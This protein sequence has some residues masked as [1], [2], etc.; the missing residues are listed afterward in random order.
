MS[1][2]NTSN[3]IEAGLI[4]VIM[5][6]YN[7][8]I[9]YLKAAIDSVLAQ[10][11]SDFEFIIIDD[12][13][14]DDSFEFI[15]SYDDARIKL[16]CNEKNIGLTR[17]LN[18]GLEFCKGEYVARMDSDDICYPER[19]EKQ[20]LFMRGHPNTIVCGSW[21]EYIDESG[22][23]TGLKMKF[24]IPDRESYRIHLLFENRPIIIHPSAFFN[25]RLLLKYHLKYDEAFYCAQ[26]YKMWVDCI[27]YADC[28][29]I[30]DYLIQYRTHSDSVTVA[31]RKLQ[32]DCALRIIQYQLDCLHLFLSEEN[33]P[34]HFRFL[35][36]NN[37]RLTKGMKD[38]LRKIS[39]SNRKYK[40]YDQK[41]LMKIIWTRWAEL[42]R[43]ESNE[44]PG[45]KRR[46]IM[47]SLLPLNHI[48][49]GYLIMNY[50]KRIYRKIKRTFN[51]K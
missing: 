26:D 19:F 4:S 49:I 25:R 30:Q 24:A 46:L 23:L 21:A 10:I 8:P 39:N 45:F 22:E 27:R 40:V 50:P 28:E 3:T 17:S 18:K 44:H 11:Y 47:L 38:W 42:Y 35:Y 13:S 31:K 2:S 36:A 20:L 12:G 6:N 9:P 41:K 29:I 14:T 34:T 5:C 43:I 15:K 37:K 7:T 1:H 48:I 51:W 33:Q 32:D 16:I